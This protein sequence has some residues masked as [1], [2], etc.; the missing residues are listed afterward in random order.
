MVRADLQDIRLAA[1]A[2]SRGGSG[3]PPRLVGD[4]A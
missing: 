4:R 3:M 1:N 2:N